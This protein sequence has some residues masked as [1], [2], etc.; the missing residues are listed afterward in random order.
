M[1]PAKAG[2]RRR[3]GQDEGHPED[4]DLEVVV[5]AHAGTGLMAL[6]IGDHH[7]DQGRR[8]GEEDRGEEQAIADHRQIFGGGGP[9]CAPD[10][11]RHGG[12][13]GFR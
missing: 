6:R 13:Q 2:R 7:R 10:V 12:P 4:A 1:T 8:S 11:R 9:F 3:Q 5:A